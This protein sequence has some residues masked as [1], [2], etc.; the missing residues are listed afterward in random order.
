MRLSSAVVIDIF[1]QIA[2]LCLSC[3]LNKNT[4]KCLEAAKRSVVTWLGGSHRANKSFEISRNRDYLPRCSEGCFYPG[5]TKPRILVFRAYCSVVNKKMIVC[6][7]CF[8]D[9]L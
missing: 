9:S 3:K 1:D 7:A 2:N 5:V 4:K 8:V 6:H